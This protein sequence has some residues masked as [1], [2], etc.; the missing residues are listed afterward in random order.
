MFETKYDDIVTFENLFSAWKEFVR[1]KS[2]KSDVSMFGSKLMDNLQDLYRDL[3]TRTYTHGGYTP[4]KINDPKPRDIH[5]ALVR[6][7]IVHHLLYKNL[8]QFFDTTF[9]YDSYSCRKNKGTHRAINQFRTYVL[10]VSTNK[11]KQCW[12]LKC[13]IQKFFASINHTILKKIYSEKYKIKKYYLFWKILLIVF[14]KD[15]R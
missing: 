7:R 15:C 2:K 9:I 14:Q 1:D 4:F 3:K 5:K 8:Y 6:D 10:K 13:D 11:T 12:I